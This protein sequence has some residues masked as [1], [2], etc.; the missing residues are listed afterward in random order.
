MTDFN[1]ALAH[2]LQWEGGIS[3][4]T[5]DIGKLTYRGI[6]QKFW[7][8]W[9]GWPIV[10]GLLDEGKIPAIDN[11]ILTPLVI[12]FYRV[13]FWEKIRGH[14]FADQKIAT[15]MLDTAVLCG[16]QRSKA[17]LHEAMH[18]VCKTGKPKDRPAIETLIHAANNLNPV[19]LLEEF[20]DVRVSFHEFKALNP[21][22]MQ[23]RKGWVNR[24][25]A[26]IV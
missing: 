2:V 22:Q 7:P 18:S 8:N 5:S 25:R 10:T 16:V 21:G 17:M 19:L 14:L 26:E 15:Y 11:P 1:K 6:S 23:F 9:A 13:N 4:N 12:E 3:N 20:R 24:A